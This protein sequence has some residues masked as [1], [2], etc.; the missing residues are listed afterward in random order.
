MYKPLGRPGIGHG[1]EIWSATARSKPLS[2]PPVWKS[3]GADILSSIYQ[4]IYRDMPITSRPCSLTQT[5]T[6]H[7]IHDVRIR[8]HNNIREE[9]D[10]QLFM[11]SL[12]IRRLKEKVCVRFLMSLRFYGRFSALYL[13]LHVP[14]MYTVSI[15]NSTNANLFRFLFFILRYGVPNYTRFER[16]IQIIL[17]CWKNLLPLIPQSLATTVSRR[18]RSLQLQLK[19]F[20]PILAL[21]ILHDHSSIHSFSRQLPPL[22]PS[23]RLTSVFAR[24]N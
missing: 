6:F 11:Q 15:H 3:H 13:H 12:R 2:G 21:Y 14:T 5:T 17:L 20:R 24:L 1:S 23:P 16:G 8:S 9:L 10:V 4:G 22:T 7:T 18:S 19:Q